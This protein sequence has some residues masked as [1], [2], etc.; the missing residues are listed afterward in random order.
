[1][2]EYIFALNDDH[3]LEERGIKPEYPKHS[4]KAKCE[5]LVRR[6]R[7]LAERDS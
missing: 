4:G 5:D 3:G 6:C 7:A 1:M 2:V